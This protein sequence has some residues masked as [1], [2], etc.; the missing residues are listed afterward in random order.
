MLK[1][2][3]K[4]KKINK[5]MKKFVDNQIYFLK[6]FKRKYQIKI[7]KKKINNKYIWVYHFHMVLLH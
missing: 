2:L 7:Y 1:D 4:I 6:I 3:L 5:N